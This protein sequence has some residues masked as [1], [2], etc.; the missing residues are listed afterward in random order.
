MGGAE[1]KLDTAGAMMD[2]QRSRFIYL[3]TGLIERK[4]GV[5]KTSALLI[6]VIVMLHCAAL[7]ALFFIQGCGPTARTGTPPPATTTPMPPTTKEAV[8]Y[9]PPKPAG[10]APV[11]RPG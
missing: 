10:Q 7:G 4:G 6:T 8:N 5:M 1:K 9:P 11:A 3:T 2:I